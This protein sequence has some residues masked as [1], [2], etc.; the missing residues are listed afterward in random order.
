MVNGTLNYGVPTSQYL[1]QAYSNMVGSLNFGNSSLGSGLD[2]PLDFSSMSMNGSIFPGGLG[3]MYGGAGM[4]EYY[5]MDPKQRLIY[6]TQLQKL[7]M[8]QQAEL[9]KTSTVIDSQSQGAE[10]AIVRQIGSLQRQIQK[11]ES[12]HIEAE[13]AKLL[14]AV[15]AKYQE[16]D[17]SKEELDKI[18]PQIKAEAET[19]YFQSTGTN[20]INDI[21]KHCDNSFVH[22]F[23]QFSFMGLGSLFSSDKSSDEIL[24]SITGE[25]QSKSSKPL[26]WL[27]K[28]L[29]VVLTGGIVGLGVIGLMALLKG[30]KVP[31]VKP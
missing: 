18:E 27:G 1:T 5:N 24:S 4:Q 7:Q 9:R 17:Y 14:Q 13:Y 25:E 19:L 20:L 15:K 16:A 12:D 22:G 2:T 8:Q 31:A 28:G 29:A 21:E 30:K 10:T 11:G 26:D 6:D 3:S 23:K